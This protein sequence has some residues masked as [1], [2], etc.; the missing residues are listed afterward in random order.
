MHSY[1]TNVLLIGCKN[2]V[3]MCKISFTL[4]SKEWLSLHRFSRKSQTLKGIMWKF[5]IQNFAQ[6]GQGTQEVGVEIYL[7]P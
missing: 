1:S 6:V 5:P 7:R 3:N 4:L 2:I